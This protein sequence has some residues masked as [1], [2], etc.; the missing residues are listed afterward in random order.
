MGDRQER[1][2]DSFAMQNHALYEQKIATQKK[3]MKGMSSG[4]FT[5]TQM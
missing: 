5:K 3:K 1:E 4:G 2:M